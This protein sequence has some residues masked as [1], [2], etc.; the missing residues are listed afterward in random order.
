MAQMLWQLVTWPIKKRL[1]WGKAH[2]HYS[3]EDWNTLLWLNESHIE[4][5][6][7][8]FL[9]LIFHE[10]FT[11]VAPGPPLVGLWFVVLCPYIGNQGAEVLL[12]ME[13][14]KFRPQR[15]GLS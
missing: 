6:N 12:S 15:I 1:D 2:R 14:K 10:V 13:L 5:E 8:D 11:L 7:E 4:P 9:S 3:V